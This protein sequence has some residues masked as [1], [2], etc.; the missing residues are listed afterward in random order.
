[1]FQCYSLKY[2]TFSLLHFVQKSV[3]RL[4][5]HCRSVGKFIISIFL[6]SMFVLI[7]DIYLSVSDFTLCNRL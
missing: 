4:H 5:L 3:L 6:D 1:M 2:P 7:Y